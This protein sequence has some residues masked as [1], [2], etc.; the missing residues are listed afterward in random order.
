MAHIGQV[1]Y[2]NEPVERQ[3]GF[4]AIVQTG[5]TL[6]LA[7]I[8]AV[9]R[10]LNVVA[11]GDMAGQVARIYDIMEETLAMSGATLKHVVNE[12]IFAT[13]LDA[14]AQ[15]GAVRAARYANCAPQDATAVQVARLFLPDALVEIQATAV[16]D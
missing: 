2:Y 15:A 3:L 13:D 10:E 11:R 1:Q 5:K 8:I 4:A 7:G 12:L 14:F 16:L 9:D 6:R